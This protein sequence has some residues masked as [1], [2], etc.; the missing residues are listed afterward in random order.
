MTAKELIRK[1]EGI[2]LHL[3]TDGVGKLT[4]G[5]GHNI[6]E[7]GISMKVAEAILQEDID[8]A[9]NGLKTI[10]D[11]FEDLP[12]LVKIVMIDM[13]FN[14]GYNRFSKFKKMI[15]AIKAEDW[16]KAAEEAKDS[17]WC[18]QLPNRCKDNYAILLGI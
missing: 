9:V 15:A 5:F 11:N 7:N 17:K 3:Y 2:K 6:E 10:F 18:K 16:K 1:H 8:I 14:L 12:H 4:I 13:M